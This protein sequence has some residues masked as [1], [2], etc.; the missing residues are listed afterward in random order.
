MN[1]KLLLL[2]FILSC[3]S[4]GQC[5]I[6]LNQNSCSADQGLIEK[7]SSGDFEYYQWYYKP[8]SSTGDFQ[9]IPGENSS[10]LTF[11]WAMFDQSLIKVFVANPTYSFNSNTI[12]VDSENCSLGTHSF[13]EELFSL[14]PN[15]ADHILTLN[16][17]VDNFQ[18]FNALGQRVLAE[19]TLVNG[20]IDIS[21]LS[22]GAYFFISET[23]GIKRTTKFLKR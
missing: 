12:I 10:S 15:P 7:V 13:D 23:S 2:C 3:S 6:E 8:L 11:D 18:I 20:Q 19:S 16:A 4:Y 17:K 14:A 22:A 21:S 9:V 1:V 5:V